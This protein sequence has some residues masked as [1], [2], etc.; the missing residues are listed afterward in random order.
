MKSFASFLLLLCCLAIVPPGSVG[1]QS[2]LGDDNAIRIAEAR[3]LLSFLRSQDAWQWDHAPFAILL[4]T[5]ERDFLMGHPYPSYDFE[6]E[7]IDPILGVEVFSRPRTEA[8]SLQFLATFPAVNGLSTVV[9]GTAEATGRSSTAWVVTLLHEHFHQIQYAQPDYQ[10]NV[11]ALDL[12]G[13]DTSGMWMLNYP[14]PYD[15]PGIASSIGQ[16]ADVMLNTEATTTD[17]AQ[18]LRSLK[19]GLPAPDYRYLTFQF[20][21]EGTARYMEHLV[22]RMAAQTYEPTKAFHALNDA[23]SYADHARELDAQLR[24]ELKSLDVASQGRFVM[25]PLG[26]MIGMVLQREDPDW[27][28]GYFNPRL[29]TLQLLNAD[30]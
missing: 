17:I 24:S 10:D 2:V 1:Q 29:S 13:G 4:L 11:A 14:F 23:V 12:D 20:W 27:M 26:A 6:S 30:F 19:Q 18:V 28:S 3:H 8:W 21:Q 15:E 25:Y 7:G 5:E 22:S 16:L 9:V